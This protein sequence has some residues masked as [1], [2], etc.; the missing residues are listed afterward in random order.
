[1]FYKNVLK[2]RVPMN[3]EWMYS[4]MVHCSKGNFKTVTELDINT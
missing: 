4:K 2:N 1:M 3:T